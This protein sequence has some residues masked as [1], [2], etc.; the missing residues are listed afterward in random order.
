[1]INDLKLR[2][3]V[4]IRLTG[5][6]GFPLTPVLRLGIRIYNVNSL[7]TYMYAGVSPKPGFV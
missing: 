5:L 7:H 2:T 6:Q 3:H 1:M 4:Q